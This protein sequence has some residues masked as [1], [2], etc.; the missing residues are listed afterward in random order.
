MAD[1][2]PPPPR[3]TG[4]LT[5]F[6]WSSYDVPF[7]ARP[8]SGAGRWHR[9]GDEPTQYWTLSPQAAWAEL[10][11]AEALHTEADVALVAMPLWTCRTPA[12]GL[13]DLREPAIQAARG[14][15]AAGLIADDW[16]SCQDAG[17]CLRVTARGVIAPSAVLPGHASLVLFGDRRAI[18]WSARPALASAVPATVVAIG[19]PEPG[20]LQQVRHRG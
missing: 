1:A 4:T 17:R 14:V 3:A 11:R 10:L 7:W 8:N 9:A 20:L 2:D 13:V 5:A 6:C 12:A 15:T 16:S 19:R 18:D